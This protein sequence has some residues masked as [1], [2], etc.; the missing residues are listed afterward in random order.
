MDN[1]NLEQLVRAFAGLK[2]NSPIFYEKMVEHV[3]SMNDSGVSKL[4]TA[5]EPREIFKSQGYCQALDEL[6]Q[7]M[8]DPEALFRQIEQSNK[9]SV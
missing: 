9:Q 4:K 6:L 3:N 8:S 5:S 2:H 7:Y 1:H